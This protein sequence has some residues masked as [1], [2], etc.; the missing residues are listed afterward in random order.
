MTEH[1]TSV[2]SVLFDGGHGYRGVCSGCTWKGIR[3]PYRNAAEAQARAHLAYSA[4]V[5]AMT[6][7]APAP[8]AALPSAG[9]GVR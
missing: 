6:T 7:A 2:I 9:E 1:A 4:E 8:R 3:T 5:K